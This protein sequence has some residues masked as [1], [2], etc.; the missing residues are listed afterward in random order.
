MK[1]KV[2]FF[3]AVLGAVAS[4]FVLA[5]QSAAQFC[6]EELKDGLQS[7]VENATASCSAAVPECSSLTGALTIRDVERIA[8]DRCCTRKRVK[9]RRVCLRGERR[10]YQGRH[11]RGAQREF[12]REARRSIS[13]LVQTDC[14]DNAYASLF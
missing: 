3:S 2:Y 13:D 14:N 9:A 7:C 11:T 5:D 10:K 6:S 1:M 8:I 4:V 12:Y